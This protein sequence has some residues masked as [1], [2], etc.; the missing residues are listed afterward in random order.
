MENKS[1]IF[2]EVLVQIKE[3]LI[4]DKKDIY[5]LV[6]YS[7]LEAI[8]LLVVALT[9][10][11]IINAVLA[12][13][14]ISVYVLAFTVIIIFIMIVSIQVL[15]EHMIEKFEESIFVKNSIQI[16]K[17]ALDKKNI[18]VDKYMN[19]F[20][21]VLSIQKAFPAILLNGSALIVKIIIVLLL[22]LMFDPTFFVTGIFSLIA[23]I[24]LTLFLGKNGSIAAI[25][26]SDA[27]H[28]AIFY[29][30]HIPTKNQDKNE[31]LEGLDKLLVKFIEAREKM[32]SII[33]KQLSLTFFME[34]VILSSFFIVGGYLIFE[35]SLTIGEF[36]TAE[37]IIMSLTYSLKDFIKQIDYVYNM[38]E[39]LYKI[40]KLS[41]ALEKK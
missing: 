5:F 30:Q 34:G 17:L 1:G 20:F 3:M 41:D 21:D 23:Y 9:T 14:T 37:I 19:Y 24:L 39:A 26:R 33:I 8:L 16:S 15:K 10:A 36:I 13:A 6:Y 27:K 25:E 38:I 28:Q 12:H 31:I 32:F 29:L 35:G 40:N 18:S 4:E 22:L 2:R 11:F 7:M